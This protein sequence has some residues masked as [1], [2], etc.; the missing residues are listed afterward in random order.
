MEM[1]S[2]LQLA[3]FS[4]L[5]ETTSLRPVLSVLIDLKI[6]SARS[7]TFRLVISLRH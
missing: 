7:D 3:S 4:S 5:D 1:R 6:N 2:K